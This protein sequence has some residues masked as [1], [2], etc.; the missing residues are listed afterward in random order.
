MHLVLSD[1]SLGFVI[2]LDRAGCVAL[3]FVVGK[4]DPLSPFLLLEHEL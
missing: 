1:F 2:F 4:L 3:Y